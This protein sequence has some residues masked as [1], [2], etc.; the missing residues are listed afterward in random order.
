MIGI[1]VVS[2]SEPLADGVIHLAGQMAP[3]AVLIGAGGLE[4][5]SL[6]TSYEKITEAIEQALDQCSDGV[7]VC[8]DLGSAVMT[9]EMVL[10]D[11]DNEKVKMADCPLVEGVFTAAV[12]APV[13]TDLEALKKEV[14]DTW[15][16]R[17]I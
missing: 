6:G 2:H 4:D 15:N 1:V 12:K 17:K 14:E 10:D 9:T 3:D 13:Q 8:M 16:S 7:L 11:L 5:G